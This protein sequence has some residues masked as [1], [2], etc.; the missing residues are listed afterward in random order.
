MHNG[1]ENTL[2]ARG[3]ERSQRETVRRGTTLTLTTTHPTT[4]P[5]TDT[6]R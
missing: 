1:N 4:Q 2:T 5:T 6:D 3:D